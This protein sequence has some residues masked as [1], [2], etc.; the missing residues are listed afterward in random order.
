[1]K[2]L[3]LILLLSLVLANGSFAK[4][5]IDIEM[6]NKSAI[7]LQ[8]AIS[9]AEKE[10]GGK[11]YAAAIDDDSFSPQF[12]VEVTKDGKVFEVRIDGMTQK[13]IGSREERD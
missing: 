6:I 13:V 3:I 11:A 10:I 4:D 8:Q 7:T 12:E 5:S 9:I 1:M 2:K